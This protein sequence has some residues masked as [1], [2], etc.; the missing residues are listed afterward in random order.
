M[1]KLFI[2]LLF[3]SFETTLCAQVISY[4]DFKSVIPLIQKE[5]FKGAFEKTS[6]LLNTT[7][8]DSSDFRGIITYMN[9]YSSAG[10]VSLKQMSH[11]DFQK[12]A[13]KFIGQK[14]VMSAHPCIDSS[15]IGFNSLKFTIQNGK[16]GAST[17]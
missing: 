2:L 3:I 17:A 8:N 16:L 10:M 11:D 5:D 14:I 12:N 15:S 6:S 13:K 1:K 9:I 7:Q 4:E